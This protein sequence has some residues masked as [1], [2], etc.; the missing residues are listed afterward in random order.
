MRVGNDIPVNSTAARVL[1]KG[2]G[3][4]YKPMESATD[5]DLPL[6]TMKFP[7]F[8]GQPALKDLTGTRFGRLTV[9]GWSAEKNSRW[10]C[11]C[12]CGMYTLRTSR[13]IKK[14]AKDSTCARCYL[15]A[16]AK[17]NE[18]YR[19]TGQHKEVVEFLK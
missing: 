17:K 9:L 16:L 2:I 11:R 19:R 8:P 10:V 3:H 7:G 13:A 1:A 12:V 6:A 4:D 5:S 15:M 18:F 14:A